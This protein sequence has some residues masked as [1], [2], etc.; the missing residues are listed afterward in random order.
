RAPNCV[1]I[2]EIR[3][4]ICATSVVSTSG[5]SNTRIALGS[6]AAGA[7]T[8][9]AAGAGTGVVAVGAAAGRAPAGG[10]GDCARAGTRASVSPRAG[11]HRNGNVEQAFMK[12][13]IGSRLGRRRREHLALPLRHGALQRRG[14]GLDVVAV[15]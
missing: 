7:A 2:C 6:S 4:T 9:A 15:D 14:Q 5:L 1:C 11:S 8:G 12:R 3:P 13:I 10:T